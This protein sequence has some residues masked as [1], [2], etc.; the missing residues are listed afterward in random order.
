MAWSTSS[1]TRGTVSVA[2]DGV[3]ISRST[4]GA[5]ESGAVLSPGRPHEVTIPANGLRDHQRLA[6]VLYD[7]VAR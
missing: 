6:L 3:V 7:E 5:L 4:A 2:V 1:G